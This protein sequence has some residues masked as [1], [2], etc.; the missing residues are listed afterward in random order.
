[1]SAPEFAAYRDY[2]AH[3]GNHDGNAC[4]DTE[5]LLPDGPATKHQ[6]LLTIRNASG[7]CVGMAWLTAHKRQPVREAFVM[8]F[9]IYPAHRRHGYAKD[10][11]AAVEGYAA[12][13]GLPQISISVSP[14][15]LPA[16]SLC[17]ASGFRP[18]YTR[19]T[20]RLAAKA[21]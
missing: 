6:H 11:M 9:V 10:A 3:E 21:K 18:L 17:E 12:Q 4:R 7:E 15:N 16:R 5:R 14:D 2:V 20:K 13:L 19:M 8:D 1:M